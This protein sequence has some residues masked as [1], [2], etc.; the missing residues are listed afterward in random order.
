MTR[1]S[2]PPPDPWSSGLRAI[3]EWP[4]DQEELA[5]PRSRRASGREH[6]PRDHLRAIHVTLEGRQ[7]H[8]FRA[9]ATGTVL[10]SGKPRGDQGCSSW[11][12]T[13]RI[14]WIM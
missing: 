12:P 2:W 13:Q 10:L 8:P 6:D 11:L 3:L 1:R 5:S 9:G 4:D 7:R 14:L